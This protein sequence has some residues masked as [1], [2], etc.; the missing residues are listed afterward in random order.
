M[1]ITGATGEVGW[2]VAHQAAAAGARVFLPTRSAARAASLRR[3]FEDTGVVV[4]TDVSTPHGVDRLFAEIDDHG[5]L[6]HVVAP[7]G[8]YWNGGLS[9]LQDPAELAELLD[10]YAVTQ[11]RLA[12]AAV[13][14]LEHTGGSYTLVSGAAGE[15]IVDGTGLLTMAVR[16]QYAVAAVL[17]HELRN[18]PMRFNEVRIA[19]RIERAGRPGV[20]ESQRAGA[21]FVDVM[22]ARTRGEVIRFSPDLLDRPPTDA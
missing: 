2:G 21:F 9:L 8:A 18:S 16:A 14:R 20:V 4:A 5:A 10:T 12:G 1:L 19:A 17:I 3:E 7:I 6:D 13:P 11:L 22:T 15:H